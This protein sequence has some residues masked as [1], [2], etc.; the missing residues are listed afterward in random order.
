MRMGTPRSEQGQTVE[1]SY[2]WSGGELYRRIYD[3][4]DRSE[5]WSRADAESRD[6]LADSSYDAGGEDHGPRVGRW[7]AC[8]APEAQV[9]S[10]YRAYDT[11]TEWMGPIRTAL[12]TAKRDAEQHDDGCVSQGGYGSAIVVREVDGRCVTLDGEYVWPPHG[13]STGAVRWRAS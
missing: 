10:Y 12:S 3:R 6:R 8:A 9:V 7:I 1:C 5:S 2:G 4:S 11:T 13:R